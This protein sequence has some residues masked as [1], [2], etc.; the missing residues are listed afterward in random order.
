MPP[1][2][3]APRHEEGRGPFREYSLKRSSACF[4]YCMIL[5]AGASTNAD[6]ADNLSVTLQRDS[7]GENHDS[8]GIGHVDPEELATGLGVL[9]QILG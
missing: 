2:E 1:T 8:S 9:R 5:L 6:R 3:V 4:R 7:P